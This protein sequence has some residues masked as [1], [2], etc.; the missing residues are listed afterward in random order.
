MRQLDL[1]QP[2]EDIKP[3]SDTSKD[4]VNGGA[5]TMLIQPPKRVSV[6]NEPEPTKVV[7]AKEGKREK[8]HPIQKE[9][10]FNGKRGRKSF[11]E[12]DADLVMVEVPM[13]KY[14]FKKNIML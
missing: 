4:K 12:M 3:Q 9:T 8:L 1:F 6:L 7:E 13:T 10:T 2:V 11:K 14:F 5:N